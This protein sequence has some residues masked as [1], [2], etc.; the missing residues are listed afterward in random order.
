MSLCNEED[1][2]MLTVE[3]KVKQTNNILLLDWVR[4]MSKE[5]SYET[6]YECRFPTEV[7]EWFELAYNFP[8]KNIP[9]IF[10]TLTVDD[11]KNLWSNQN[12]NSSQFML[13]LIMFTTIWTR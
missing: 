7:I 12:L 8:S 13:R 10:F 6:I 4:N 9:P 11:K 2:F 3:I 5:D 1:R